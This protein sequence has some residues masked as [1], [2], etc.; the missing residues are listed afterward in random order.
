M[1]N[2]EFQV[3]GSRIEVYTDSSK[4][5]SEAGFAV[6]ILDHGE[7]YEILKFKLGVNNTAFQAELAAIDFAVRWALGKKVK[8]N[9]FTDSQSSIETLRSS[10]YRSEEVIRAKENFNL[11]GG[12][13]GLAWIKAQARNPR[14]I[15]T[16]D[17]S[18]L[19]DNES[20]WGFKTLL[21][22]KEEGFR[23]SPNARFIFKLITGF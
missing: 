9:I 19:D 11:A 12:H 15:I 8:V 16:A 18:S 22:E 5:D 21:L 7:P 3:P 6:C 2:I 10:G 4:S 17:L 1:L 20:Q 23:C 13:I 14:L